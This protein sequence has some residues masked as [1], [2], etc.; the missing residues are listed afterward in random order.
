MSVTAAAGFRAAGVAAG[1]K[2]SGGRDVALVVNDG[3]WTDVPVGYVYFEGQ[4]AHPE[5]VGALPGE[6]DDPFTPDRDEDDDSLRPELWV[7]PLIAAA[8][9]QADVQVLIP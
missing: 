5:A 4:W 9:A 6:L 1:L 3:R 8:L 7:P 2:S